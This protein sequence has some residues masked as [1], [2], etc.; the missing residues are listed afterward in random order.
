MMATKNVLVC[1]DDPVQLK[2]LTSLI[3]LAGYRSL[4]AQTPGEAMM[5]AR[6]CGIDAVVTDVVLPDGDGFDLVRD[7]RR[8]GFDAPVFM[9]SAH[10]SEGMK[11][12][13]RNAGVKAFF[14]K[15]LSLSTIRDRVDAVLR[16]SRM[17]NASVLLVESDPERRARLE[18]TIAEAGFAV[19]SVE[20]G[21][22]ALEAVAPR[23]GRTDL[24]LM[25]L[26]SK[27]AAGAELI[28]KAL[29]VRP[30]LKIVMMS[31]EAGT[32]DIR[33]GYEAGAAAFVRK[34]ISGERL[35]SFLTATFERLVVERIR[36]EMEQKRNEQRAADPVARKTVRWAKGWMQAPSHSRK[37]RR[38]MGLAGMFLGLVLGMGVAAGLQTSY[39]EADRLDAMM[40]RVI[41]RTA[42]P[43]GRPAARQIE[44]AGRLQSETQLQLMREANDFTRRYYE[45][46]LE[47]LKRQAVLRNSSEP[48]TTGKNRE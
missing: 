25:N 42:A 38:V 10:A 3:N 4:S 33:A 18:K 45:G 26:H 12:K 46:H 48:M 21:E 23:F 16:T 30:S 34:S 39:S 37:G 41:D 29:A 13:A 5:K 22:E 28:R 24:L 47:E 19:S 6:R 36:T 15:P 11:E 44:S 7:L 17:Q 14:E 9:T 35:Q 2:V 20:T 43:M 32:D 40:E 31:D 8:L 27:G 1:E